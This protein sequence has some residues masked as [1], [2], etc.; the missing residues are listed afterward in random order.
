M[1]SV[2]RE[3][4]SSESC[5]VSRRGARAFAREGGDG[6]E[7]AYVALEGATYASKKFGSKSEI[8]KWAAVGNASE[9]GQSVARDARREGYRI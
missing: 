3:G 2:G 4:T 7:F 6:A 5:G 1:R 9:R 8:A